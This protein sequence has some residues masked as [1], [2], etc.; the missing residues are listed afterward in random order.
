MVSTYNFP[1]K[2][3]FGA[4]AIDQLPDLLKAAGCARPL[5]VTD[6]HVA[7]LE[8]FAAIK[9]PSSGV[10]P[11]PFSNAGG[12]PVASQVAE[13]VSAYHAG[14]CDAVVSVGG[15]APIDVAKA[16]ALMVHHPGDLFDYEDGKP[17]GRPVDQPIPFQVAVAT[18]SGTGSE[19]GRSSVISDDETKAKKIIFDPRMLPNVAILDPNLTVG[20]PKRATAAT[21]MDALTHNVEAYLSKGYHPMADGIALEGARMCSEHL[22]TAYNEPGNIEARTA[23]LAA[24]MMGAVAFQ[25][26][27]GITHSLAHPLSTVCDLH[28]GLANA[29][30][31]PH[32][33][34][35]NAAVVPKRIERLAQTVGAGNS[36]DDFVDWLIELR[37]KLGIPN[38]LSEVGVTQDHLDA[39]VDYAF[40]DVCHASNPRSPEK[41]DFRTLYLA[42]M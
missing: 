20:L 16:I 1:T 17:D 37:E 24:S 31:I 29:I 2:I 22:L 25:K 11:V 34:R 40:A 27:L 23:M 5:L 36:V 28:H 4:G 12:N 41:S 6:E 7:A 26:G 38:T 3:V 19:V 33:M 39:L 30:M 35:F 10:T 32:A 14:D 9:E 8:F 42:A 18:T 13:G 21:G 15:G